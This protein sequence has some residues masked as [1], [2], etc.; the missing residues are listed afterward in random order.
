MELEKTISEA[1]ADKLEAELKTALEASKGDDH[2]MAIK[3][4][5]LP[6]IAR[7]LT[8]FAYQD[9]EFATAVTRGGDLLANVNNV[10]KEITRDKPALSDVEVY[11]KAVKYYL[12]AAAVTVSFRITIP[13][14]LD[15]DLADINLDAASETHAMIPDLFDSGEVE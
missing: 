2:A 3:R 4:A 7:M 6:P 9:E 14:E 10:V 5:L 8:K 11:A 1:A 12:P 15:A 13:N